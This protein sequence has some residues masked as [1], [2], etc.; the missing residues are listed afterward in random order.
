MRG[1]SPSVIYAKMVSPGAVTVAFGD[2]STFS[3]PNTHPNFQK[4]VEAVGR[5]APTSEIRGLM[6]PVR[7][8]RKPLTWLS[9]SSHLEGDLLQG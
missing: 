8:L 2:A 4:A 1:T 6:Q 3:W 9:P 5:D 7:R